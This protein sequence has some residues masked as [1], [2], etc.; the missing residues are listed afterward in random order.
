MEKNMLY[1]VYRN[2]NTQHSLIIINRFIDNLFY[3]TRTA[4]MAS[5]HRG[6]QQTPRATPNSKLQ[7][8]NQWTAQ[9]CPEATNVS[10]PATVNPKPVIPTRSGGTSHTNPVS[11]LSF[12]ILHNKNRPQ[13]HAGDKKYVN[14]Q[15]KFALYAQGSVHAHAFSSHLAGIQAGTLF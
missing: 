12:E 13:Y 8:I 14:L 7:T 9:A 10:G 11:H 4:R 1:A 5:S 15:A 6:C 3:G 2:I